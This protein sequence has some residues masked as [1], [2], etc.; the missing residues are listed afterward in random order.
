MTVRSGGAR[1]DRGA[2]GDELA[3]ILV[4]IGALQV[5]FYVLL[6][7]R[8]FQVIAPRTVRPL[9]ANA[10]VI[11]GG[12]LVY[13]V[14]LGAADLAPA[15]IGAAAGSVVAAGPII[16]MLSEGWLDSPLGTAAA[17]ALAAPLCVGV[18]ALAHGA[19]WTRAEPEAWMAHAGLNAIG[20]AVILHVAIG[21]RWPSV[22]L[23]GDARRG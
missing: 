3:A 9:V 10:V 13:R 4:C 22:A 6:H 2:V 1:P 18:H 5:T 16:S 21:P 19:A 23:T 12:W 14:L 15:S 7:D 17:T 8:P 20:V 11:A